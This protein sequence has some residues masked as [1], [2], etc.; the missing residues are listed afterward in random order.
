M[1][2]KGRESSDSTAAAQTGRAGPGP[3]P[4]TR[5]SGA[6]QLLQYVGGR[7][8]EPA[9]QT[10]LQVNV[11]RFRRI[12]ASN[13]DQFKFEYASGISRR[14]GSH[15]WL[16]LDAPLCG[17]V[18]S[19]MWHSLDNCQQHRDPPTLRSH[20]GPVMI[21]QI[22]LVCIGLISNPTEGTTEISA[23]TECF[24]VILHRKV[25]LI[26][27]HGALTSRRSAAW[28]LAGALDQRNSSQ[29]GMRTV[30]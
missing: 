2:S 20:V 27:Q 17:N 8:S 13:A 21:L 22:H 4:L 10:P 24:L 28:P 26:F 23:P 12:P 29:R 5:R 6:E 16:M 7:A 3:K 11:H 15:G 19:V 14:Y 25:N 1:Q 18:Q 9:R 30:G